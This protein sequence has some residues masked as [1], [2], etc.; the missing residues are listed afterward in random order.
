MS[1]GLLFLA[2]GGAVV[3]TALLF[4]RAL[5]HKLSD[6]TAFSGFVADYG[7]LPEH[8][9]RPATHALVAAEGLTLAA[10]VVPALWPLGPVLAALMLLGYAAA[11]GGAVRMGRRWIECGCGG[12]VQP[13]SWTLVGR[14]VA[15]A[16]LALLG[17]A[18]SPFAL[19]V[20]EAAAVIASG[21]T[22]FLGY[23]LV[24]QILGN[25]AYLKPRT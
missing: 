13:V 5:V 14:N 1:G 7:L 12:A 6:V 10:L 8:F 24:E 21:F 4:A 9:V 18:G 22:V 15:L 17:A 11:I 2:S 16:A 19:D 23:L 3:F 20:G 25:A